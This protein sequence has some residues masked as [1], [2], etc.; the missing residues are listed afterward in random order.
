MHAQAGHSESC[1]LFRKHYRLKPPQHNEN[2]GHFKPYLGLYVGPGP[3]VGPTITRGCMWN[4][5]CVVF[6]SWF[7]TI[8]LLFWDVHLRSSLF[9]TDRTEMILLWRIVLLFD[10]DSLCFVII[11][12]GLAPSLVICDEVKKFVTI[13]TTSMM[14]N[15]NITWKSA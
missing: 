13:E 9:P 8:T 15:Q 10:D 12:S 7:V 11:F 3:T 4:Q 2:Y 5:I 6:S 1:K 14:N